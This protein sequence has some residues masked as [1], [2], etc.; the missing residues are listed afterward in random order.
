MKKIVFLGQIALI[1][2]SGCSLNQRSPLEGAWELVDLKY[3]TKDSIL[4]LYPHDFTGSDVAIF[5]KNHFLVVGRHKTDTTYS[6]NY[7]GAS[8]YQKGNRMEETLLYF[9]NKE[10]V[11]QKVN[12]LIEFHGDTLIKTYPVDNNGKVDEKGYN[13]IKWK[14]LK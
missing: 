11:G 1:V 8:Y 10:A 9:P 14:R 3:V 6:D 12:S 4:W 13:I 2:I 7:V 5:S